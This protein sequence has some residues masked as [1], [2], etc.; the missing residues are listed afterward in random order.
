MPIR[1]ELVAAL[2]R[3]AF[4]ARAAASTW[5]AACASD[6]GPFVPAPR[7]A[8]CVPVTPEEHAAAE[9][10]VERLLRAS[11]P[12]MRAALEAMH[13]ELQVDDAE[14]A[15]ARAAA[16]LLDDGPPPRM[17]SA[18]AHYARVVNHYIARV[19]AEVARQPPEE[20]CVD[21][22]DAEEET[23]AFVAEHFRRT[24]RWHAG[25]GSTGI[26]FLARLEPA[27]LPADE[28]TPRRAV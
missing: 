2:A 1:P 11:F 24:G 26:L 3:R 5:G 20:V 23:R 18:Q 13:A 28:T 19:N 12:R 17:P 16:T 25:V 10:E 21:L 6:H 7:C 27:A 9:E 15:L 8:H 4:F 22:S 14:A